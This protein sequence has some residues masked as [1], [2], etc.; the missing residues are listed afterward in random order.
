MRINRDAHHYLDRHLLSSDLTAATQPEGMPYATTAFL[1]HLAYGHCGDVAEKVIAQA[2]ELFGDVL[3]N[4]SMIGLR[5][6]FEGCHLASNI[7]PN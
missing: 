4:D 7:K 6:Q 5:H 1:D 2:P 3:S